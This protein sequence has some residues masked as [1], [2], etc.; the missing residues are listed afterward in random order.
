MNK[1]KGY[2]ISDAH[3]E[4]LLEEAKK[5]RQDV[6]VVLEDIIDSS[7]KKKKQASKKPSKSIDDRS[8][9]F[10]V[11]LAKFIDNPHPKSML[12]DF[13]KYWSEPNRS[14]TLMKFE[15]E[16]TWDLSRRLERWSKNNFNN[17]GSSKT[18]GQSLREQMEQRRQNKGYT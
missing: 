17:N 9:L 13:Y 14:K 7:L 12:N 15:S 18:Q 5:R 3:H 8:K 6:Y 1:V 11:E 10:I 4:R 16:K 2:R